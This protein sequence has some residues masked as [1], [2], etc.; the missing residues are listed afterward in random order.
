MNKNVAAMCREKFKTGVEYGLQVALYM[1]LAGIHNVNSEMEEP[2]PDDW[3]GEFLREL[4]PE[5]LRIWNEI[6]ADCKDI[7]SQRLAEYKI[8]ELRKKYGLKDHE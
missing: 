7:D 2:M 1:T 5:L 8:E 3:L 6:T 4:E